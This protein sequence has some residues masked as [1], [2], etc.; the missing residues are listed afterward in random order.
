MAEQYLR[1]YKLVVFNGETGEALDLSELRIRFDV[2]RTSQMTPNVADI[3]V[4]NVAPET[5]A[6]I[7]AYQ[8]KEFNNIILEAGY[9][10]N[11]GVIFKGNIKQVI[12]GRENA[13]DTFVDLV[14]GDG[15]KAYNFAVVRTTLAA[16]VTQLEQVNACVQSMG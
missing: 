11:Y 5:V 15:D 7:G 9:P 16:G 13:T 3:R 8:T 1:R 2:K 10:D 14:A 4:Y 6:R 12:S